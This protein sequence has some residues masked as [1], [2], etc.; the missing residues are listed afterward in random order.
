M[1]TV[2][3]TR[4]PPGCW[5]AAVREAVAFGGRDRA[6]VASRQR[7]TRLGLAASNIRPGAFSRG[8][9]ARGRGGRG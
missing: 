4:V 6:A 3:S 2:R 5:P 9:G 8:C 7:R 1:Y